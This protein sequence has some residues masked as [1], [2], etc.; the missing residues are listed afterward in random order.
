MPPTSVVGQLDPAV[1]NTAGF[2]LELRNIVKTFGTFT[3]LDD[4]NFN[5]KRGEVHALLGEN[6]AGKSTLMN[7]VCGLYAADSGERLHEGEP[8]WISNP[9]EA[10]ALGIGMVHLQKQDRRSRN[11]EARMH[12]RPCSWEVWRPSTA[13]TQV[14]N[15]AYMY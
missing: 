14:G 2:V 6:G 9:R 11:A 13:G 5:L 10:H 4:V 12:S 8:V 15:G 1:K 3:A 7:I